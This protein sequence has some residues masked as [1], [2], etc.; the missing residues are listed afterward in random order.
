M[1]REEYEK[2]V[3][4]SL[5]FRE[6]DGLTQSQIL[7]A[8]GE[9]MERYIT[10]FQQEADLLREAYGNFQKESDQVVLD[11]KVSVQKDKKE[12]LT[13]K[14]G[15]ARSKEIDKAEDLLKKL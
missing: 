14:E 9:E 6:M 11:Y 12:K 3:K 10:M 2:I 1:T 4:N 5:S 13:A 7:A 15:A 8:V